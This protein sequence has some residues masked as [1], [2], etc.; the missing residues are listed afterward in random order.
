MLAFILRR[1]GQS[2]VVMLVVAVVSFLMFRYV[3]D[4]II[5]MVGQEAS[6][7]DQE[8]LRDRLGLNDPFYVQFFRFITNALQGQ[9]GI[10]YRLQ[11]PVTELILS[12]LPATIELAL[13]SATMALAVGLVLGVFTA[14]RPKSWSTGAIMSASLVG[15]SLP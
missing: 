13:V 3:G 8:A 10:S 9:F 4:P 2:V 12:R 15:V 14:L 6:I 5:S 11:T 7:A 1:L